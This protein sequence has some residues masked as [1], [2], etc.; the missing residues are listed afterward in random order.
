M[1]EHD[2]Q[3]ALGTLLELAPQLG[4]EQVLELEVVLQPRLEAALGRVLLQVEEP[5]AET[6]RASD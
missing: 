4:L 2:R 3:L 6:H 5:S 1:L